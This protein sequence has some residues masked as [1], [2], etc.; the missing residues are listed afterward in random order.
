MLDFRSVILLETNHPYGVV[1]KTGFVQCVETY[2]ITT[3]SYRDRNP[4]MVVTMSE[5][6]KRF[7]LKKIH[8]AGIK[9]P[10]TETV[11]EEKAV[12]PEEK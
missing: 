2:N 8:I 6:G 5:D 10:K 3:K 7:L 4:D 9:D 12:A 11:Q 1:T